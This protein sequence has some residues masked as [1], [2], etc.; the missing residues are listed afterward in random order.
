MPSNPRSEQL[1]VDKLSEEAFSTEQLRKSNSLKVVPVKE[2]KPVLP[3]IDTSYKKVI[4]DLLLR[5]KKNILAEKSILSDTLS[6][7]LEKAPEF[8]GGY[9]AIQYYFIK[10]QHYPKVALLTG[11]SG[12]TIVSFVINVK[13]LVEDAKVVSGIDPELDM[14]AIRLVKAMPAW[15]PAIYKG[16]PIACMLIMPVNFSIR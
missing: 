6:I 9:M 4:T 14:E 13:G 3:Q 12:S 8:P 1:H 2:H 16:K 11:I 5:H 15:Q 7:V 10:N